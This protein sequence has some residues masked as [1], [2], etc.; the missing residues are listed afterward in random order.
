MAGILF[1]ASCGPGPSEVESETERLQHLRSNVE[2]LERIHNMRNKVEEKVR[3]G[4]MR[5]DVADAMRE[6]EI[7]LASTDGRQW[8]WKSDR[9]PECAVLMDVFEYRTITSHPEY[10][11]E[12]HWL[13]VY[14][15]YD[16]NERVVLT[17][18]HYQKTL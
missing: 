6:M 4:M 10:I 2:V 15:S 3:A 12:S 18:S 1:S 9:V 16:R 7:P 5:K 17:Y 14:V 13:Q 8:W 11:A